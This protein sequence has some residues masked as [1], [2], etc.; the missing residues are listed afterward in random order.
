MNAHQHPLHKDRIQY[1][2]LKVNGE[3]VKISWRE[4]LDYIKEHVT[5]IQEKNGADALGVYGSASITN[6]EAYLL[7][8]FARVALKQSILITMDAYVCQLLLLLLVKHLAWTEDLRIAYK[9]F[10][11]LNV[12]C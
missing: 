3:F 9:R 5:E 4:A 12:L 10:R 11:L 8:K 7:G 2:L 1:P 6:E